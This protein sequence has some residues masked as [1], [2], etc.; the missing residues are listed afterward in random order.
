MKYRGTMVCAVVVAAAAVAPVGTAGADVLP[1]AVGMG[2]SQ[3]LD[4][5]M[6]LL[7]DQ[8]S[9][10][11]CQRAG[12]GLAWTPVQTPFPPNDIWLSY[13][14]AITL[15]GQGMRN[16][17]LSAGEWTA[18]PQDADT[19]CAVT[20]TD[21]VEAGVLARPQVSQG[22]QGKPLTVRMDTSLFYVELAGNCLWVKD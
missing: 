12:M 16:P 10:V 2:C 8:T 1:P 9:Y 5:A 7:P 11:I 3:E 19:A 22:E 18:T 15:H 4:G 17:N 21:V 13:G 6:T 14:P 20:Q